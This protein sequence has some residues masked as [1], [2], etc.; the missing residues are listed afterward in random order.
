MTQLWSFYL[1]QFHPIPENDHWWGRGFT[2]W[3]NVKTAKPQFPGHH[4]PHQPDPDLGY[5]DLREPE[6]MVRQAALA[7]KY[8][9]HGFVFYHYWFE[10]RRL[11]EKPVASILENKHFKMPFCL[12]WANE[13]WSRRWDGMDDDVIMRQTYSATDDLAHIRELIPFF[14][15]ERYC[16]HRGRPVLLVYRSEDLPDPE[17]TA[18]LWRQEVRKA[19]F[20]DIYLLRVEGIT[21]AIDPARHGFDAAVEFA[22]D[23]RCLTRQVYIDK[24]GRSHEDSSV[25][26]PGSLSNRVFL[27]EDIV[28]AMLAKKEPSYKR[29]PCVFPA[30]DNSARRQ[31]LSATIIYG[32]SPERYRRFL[33][34]VVRRTW[35]KFAHDDRLIFINAWNEWG[36]GCHLEPDL[37]DGFGFLQ[38]TREV[39]QSEIS[40]S[41][42]FWKW[43][44][45]L[46]PES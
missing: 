39:L 44:R 16:K 34:E 42:R 24:Y 17:Q 6:V 13:N 23:W 9:I 36:E 28:L 3:T 8:G 30:W 46:F 43:L 38:A 21:D 19:G 18:E 12:C 25:A 5:Y 1:P 31:K 41:A 40:R 33:E 37:H 14:R 11:L 15:D 10:G 29:Y 7:R 26:E 32:N 4:Q 20:K 35:K 45:T 22:P 2:E 27:Y